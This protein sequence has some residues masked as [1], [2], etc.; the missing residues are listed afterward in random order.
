[1]LLA[2]FRS[3]FLILLEVGMVFQISLLRRV[4][5][6]GYGDQ[7]DQTFGRVVKLASIR[8]HARCERVNYR[9]GGFAHFVSE[10][11]R[12]SPVRDPG[13]ARARREMD[14]S[15]VG[16]LQVQTDLTYASIPSLSS[17]LHQLTSLF[18]QCPALLDHVSFPL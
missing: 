3:G 16:L 8:R 13:D 4:A 12:A 18:S 6:A 1:M 5:A 9:K 15:P 17:Y 10:S 14:S 11:A 7:R 2:L